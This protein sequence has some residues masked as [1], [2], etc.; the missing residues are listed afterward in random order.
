MRLVALLAILLLPAACMRVLDVS[1]NEWS[2]QGASIQ[3]V[4]FDEIECAR[5][6]ERVGQI[7]DTI[8]GGVVDAVV[9]Q[10]KAAQRLAAHDRCMR[11][12]GY[13]HV[14]ARS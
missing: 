4:T 14:A 13:Q 11:D 8:V 1:G 9:V 6:T 10:L 2:R 5:A 7:P 12:K 3:Q